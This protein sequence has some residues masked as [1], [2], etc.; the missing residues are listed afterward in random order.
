MSVGCEISC[1]DIVLHG[2]FWQ[3]ISNSDNYVFYI[4]LTLSFGYVDI[5]QAIHYTT[6]RN[7]DMLTYWMVIGVHTSLL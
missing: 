2:Q 5:L 6:S 4:G 3:T 1:V 7:D